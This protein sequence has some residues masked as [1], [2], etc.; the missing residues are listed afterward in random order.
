MAW[1]MDSS[2]NAEAMA[3]T[4]VDGCHQ[5]ALQDGFAGAGDDFIR[6][7][8]FARISLGWEMSPC[9]IFWK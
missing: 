9:S 5:A 6:Q 4:K 7:R 2:D 3:W 8:Q 1:T